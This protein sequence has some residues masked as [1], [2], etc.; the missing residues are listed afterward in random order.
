MIMRRLISLCLV[1]VLMFGIGT[2]V[3]AEDID[4]NGEEHVFDDRPI[5]ERPVH[6]TVGNT[7]KVSGAFFTNQFGNNTSDMDVRKM[8]YGY[9]LVEW[10]N[11]V[12]FVID[13]Q[14]VKNLDKINL[15][16]GV[17]Y[18]LKLQEDLFY[19]D[20]VTHIT[21]Y[22]Y[23]FS[24]LLQASPYFAEIGANTGAWSHIVGFDSYS[25]GKTN[26]FKGV[27]IEDEYT[28]DIIVS[29]EYLPYFYEL[30]YLSVYPYPIDVI[31]P[32]CKVIDNGKGAEII[33]SNKDIKDPIFG[34]ELL[35]NTILDKDNGYL[36][37]PKLTA[38]PYIL[39]SYDPEFGI[40]EFVMNPYYKGDY[41]TIK[42]Y[43]DTVT[44]VPVEIDSMIDRLSNGEIDIL[45]KCVDASVIDAGLL[46]SDNGV[47]SIMYPRLGYGFLAVSCEQ[48]AQRSE[49]VRQAIACCIDREA[50]VE[51]ILDVYGLE[52]YSYYGIGQWM[53]QVTMGLLMD[54]NWSDDEKEEWSEITL[55]ALDHYD[56]DI[57]RARQL[58]IDDGWNVN[59]D[60]EDYTNGIRYKYFEDGTLVPL[61]FSFAKCI[62]NPAAELVAE[63]LKDAFAE[64]GAE[65]IVSDVT[66]NELLADHYRVDGRKFDLSFMATNFVSVFDPYMTLVNDERYTGA[67]N[68]SGIDDEKL[69]RLAWDLHTCD[70]LDQL[71]FLKKWI[72]FEEYYNEVLPTVPIYTNQYVDFVA[73]RVH[74]YD[75]TSSLDWPMAL[76]NAW[77]E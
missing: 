50:F 59:Q 31:A 23:A 8:V 1:I 28:L 6:V 11:Q 12:S 29:Y 10:D 35:T 53:T 52:C 49:A 42:P 22:D 54:D 24:L 3:N 41:R 56:Y 73:E 17:E 5:K 39:E 58:L 72:A 13:E 69:V 60:G 30:S 14:V 57:T 16:D 47:N 21:A 62:G 7:S 65:L 48:G 46:L 55:E 40:V 67:M 63:M 75:I 71:E 33:N 15:A 61:K 66:F 74:G 64:I 25:K 44:L 43:I 37:Y 20:G 19:N 68:T 26:I 18:R 4:I 9:N 51:Q 70:S 27:R 32:G 45:N 76:L 2:F 36:S 38:G 34:T 77:A